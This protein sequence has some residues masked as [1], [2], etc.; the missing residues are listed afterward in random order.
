MPYVRVDDQ[1]HNHPTVLTAGNAAVGLWVRCGAYSA[2]YLLDGFVPLD[3]ALAYGTRRE[4]ERAISA[5]LWQHVAP[6]GLLIPWADQWSA[7]K[8][9]AQR[10][11]TAERQRRWKEAHH[12]PGNGVTD[13]AP[14]PKPK[15]KSLAAAA[16][17]GSVA[18][19]G[20]A[21]AAVEQAI[22]LYIAHKVDRDQPRKPD[23]YRR[24]LAQD[25]PG[26]YA[27]ALNTYMTEHH[28]ASSRD[29]ARDVFGMSII[30]IRKA[31]T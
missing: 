2:N 29:I 21:A 28:A 19:N 31:T 16:G 18:L 3:V 23:A 7:D 1:V 6:A 24:T 27:D 17:S 11:T 15:P 10:V 20:A 30:D 25:I 13:A 5:G 12:A 22:Q 9:R 8:V 14:K 4:V 26:E